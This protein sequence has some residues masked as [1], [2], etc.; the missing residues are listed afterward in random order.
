M[1]LMVWL[2]SGAELQHLS[3]ARAECL[4][5][6][7]IR[8]LILVSNY[9]LNCL[10]WGTPVYKS[11]PAL[12][13]IIAYSTS[14]KEHSAERGLFFPSSQSLPWQSVGGMTAKQ[15]ASL[16]MA[17]AALPLH[18]SALF[19]EENREDMTAWDVCKIARMRQ[20]QRQ[21]S[22]SIAMTAEYSNP[23]KATVYILILW[24]EK[25]LLSVL[26]EI[27]AFYISCKLSRGCRGNAHW[28][29]EA[30]MSQNQRTWLQFL[31]GKNLIILKLCL[32][33]FQGCLFDLHS[34]R[35]LKTQRHEEGEFT[36]WWLLPQEKLI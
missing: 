23:R 25:L 21:N 27:T 4:T 5:T 33:D 22:C 13:S 2:F 26:V 6:V 18:T 36:A 8:S 32:E 35:E 30:T 9:N 15:Q 1:L 3:V 17:E 19:L 12:K 24:V 29:W 14:N 20:Q 34:I 11:L 10:I 28:C 31:H 7:K 16:G